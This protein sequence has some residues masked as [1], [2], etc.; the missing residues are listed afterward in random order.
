MNKF[1][2]NN[3]S[4]ILAFSL[5]V[6][7]ILVVV[8]TTYSPFTSVETNYNFMYTACD[9]GTGG[10]SYGCLN[11]MEALFSVKDTSLIKNDLDDSR[12]TDKDGISD[13]DEN[14]HVRIFLHDTQQ[15]E[16]REVKFENAKDYEIITDTITSP[17][18]VNVSGGYER[19]PEVFPIIDTHSSYD[20]YLTKGKSKTRLNLINRD[21]R[22]YYRDN[23]RFIG[24]VSSKIN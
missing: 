20:Y 5:P 6:A 15:N 12:D 14:Y 21:N 23:F 10:Y 11:H 2:K 18:G 7:L 24:W 8:F 3:L 22:Y 9:N 19:G 1:I 13:I 4:L 17:D 16:S